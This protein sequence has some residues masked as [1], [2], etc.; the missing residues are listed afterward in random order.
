MA[1][2]GVNDMDAT[3]VPL[4]LLMLE[5]VVEADK[6]CALMS[7]GPTDLVKCKSF[8]SLD[9][10]SLVVIGCIVASLLDE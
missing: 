10:A 6:G 7:L 1:P 2:S 5:A 9:T 4:L 3:Q 8:E